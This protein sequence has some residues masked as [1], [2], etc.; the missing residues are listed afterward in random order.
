MLFKVADA[1]RIVDCLLACHLVLPGAWAP[2]LS[3]VDGLA[4]E[5]IHSGEVFA[6]HPGAGSEP[7]EA[8]LL[9]NGKTFLV[10]LQLI[11]VTNI[12]SVEG[13]G[14]PMACKLRSVVVHAVKVCFSCS[15]D[16][17]V[18]FCEARQSTAQL[19]THAF[20]VVLL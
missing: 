12:V 20:R 9:P 4:V 17:K 18:R 14:L 16:L 8:T 2:V 6:E 10:L 13:W 7:V 19:R 3:Y 5:A 15:Q 11:D 1:I